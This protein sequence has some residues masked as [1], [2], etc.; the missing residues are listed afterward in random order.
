MAQ[1]RGST[2]HADLMRIEVF[3]SGGLPPRVPHFRSSPTQRKKFPIVGVSSKKLIALLVMICPKSSPMSKIGRAPSYS[4]RLSPKSPNSQRPI[5][6]VSLAPSSGPIGEV[7][8]NGLRHGGQVTKP[9]DAS[10]LTVSGHI[11]IIF[12]LNEEPFKSPKNS[13]CTST[14][15]DSAPKPVKKKG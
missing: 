11:Q 7:F 2:S 6:I 15:S 4:Q 5:S 9:E 8:D 1:H 10:G 3:S 14:G 12:P 13:T